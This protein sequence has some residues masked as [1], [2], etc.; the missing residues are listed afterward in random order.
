MVQPTTEGLNITVRVKNGIFL[1]SA[2]PG[3][4]PWQNS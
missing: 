4:M 1:V 2:A 3:I